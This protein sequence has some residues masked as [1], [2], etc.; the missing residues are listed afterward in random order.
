[1][2]G[3][4]NAAATT[5]AARR[6][7]SSLTTMPSVN[8]ETGL[9]GEEESHTRPGRRKRDDNRHAFVSS[10]IHIILV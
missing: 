1:M 6:S 7:S 5:R 10:T 3:G 2:A 4:R 8:A 9:T